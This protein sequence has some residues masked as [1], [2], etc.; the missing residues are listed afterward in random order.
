L[1]KRITQR[2]DHTILKTDTT[3]FDIVRV[4]D[5]AKQFGFYSVC[6]NPAFVALAKDQLKDS[7][8]KVCSVVGFPLGAST[9]ET[10]AFETED[11][12]RKGADEVD[13][14]IHIG[15]LL[16]GNWQLV[17]DDIRAVVTA[18]R[19]KLVK[20]ILET[21]LLSRDQIVRGCQIVKESGAKFVKT[22]TGF[23]T[24]G[25]TTADIA[26][27]RQTVGPDFGVKASGGLKTL[28]DFEAM[29]QAGATRLGTS[30][31][32]QVLRGFSSTEN[33]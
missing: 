27:M 7:D 5:E 31:A 32:A 16:A 21:C 1:E 23:S 19:G 9:S 10:K 3:A 14:V 12:I 33:Y 22:S 25:A 2:I 18:A 24:S 28:A 26:L 13:M 30:S 8:V 4:C 29:L 17:E 6:V 15:A 20:V 11:A